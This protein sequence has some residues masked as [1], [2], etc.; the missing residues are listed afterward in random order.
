ME[1]S[2][3]EANR[4]TASQEI[5]HILWNRK[6]H[7]R[8]HKCPPSVPILCQLDPLY[9]STSYFLKIHLNIILSSTSGSPKWSLS[10]RLHHQNP[11]Y[12]SPLEYI[13]T[14]IHTYTH[15][16][17]YA[18]HFDLSKWPTPQYITFPYLSLNILDEG[19]EIKLL[20]GRSCCDAKERK[21]KFL[22]QITIH[23]NTLPPAGCTN[24]LPHSR[25][26]C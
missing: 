19:T 1:Q 17:T 18:S 5:P 4:F 11:V 21:I 8:I 7:Y 10:F 25:I 16:H 26:S 22:R 12:A 15:T 9:T 6:V 23:Y 3:W 13:H 2:P 14:Y 24:F 20:L